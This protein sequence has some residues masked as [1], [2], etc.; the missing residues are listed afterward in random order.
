M[1]IIE[2][3]DYG[4][5]EIEEKQ[6][7][8]FPIGI[9]GFEDYHEFALLDAHQK[10]YFVLQSLEDVHVAFV[11]IKPQVFRANYEPGIDLD[12]LVS[13]EVENLEDTVV[14]AIVTIPHAQG[15]I[16]ANLQGPLYVNKKNLK[17]M[18]CISPKDEYRTRHN[19]LE[20]LLQKG[21]EHADPLP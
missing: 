19:I 7:L 2:T 6:K 16:S 17:G 1:L 18:Q 3:R 10:P 20:E 4:S 12:D 8:Y 14:F 11:L 21:Q 9:L 13:I 5:V 15:G